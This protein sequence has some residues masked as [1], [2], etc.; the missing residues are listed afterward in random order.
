M[1]TEQTSFSHL[2]LNPLANR[3]LKEALTT[4]AEQQCII[5]P[6][7]DFSQ[8]CSSGTTQ[9]VEKSHPHRQLEVVQYQDTVKLM[10]LEKQSM[11]V[12]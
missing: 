2:A 4:P 1:Q 8:L 12:I 6:A 11:I 3:N 5:K 10:W 7:F 9:K